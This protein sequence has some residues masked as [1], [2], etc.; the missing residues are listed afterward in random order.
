MG[1][2]FGRRYI[3]KGGAHFS[4]LQASLSMIFSGQSVTHIHTHT[5]TH[6]HT[7]FSPSTSVLKL[8]SHSREKSLLLSSCPSVR[9]SACISRAPT[10]RISWKFGMWKLVWKPVKIVQIWLK[11]GKISGNFR[12]YL[13]RFYGRRWHLIATVVLFSTDMVSGC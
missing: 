9:L 13:N 2:V 4:P 5:H 12:K 11:P 3:K 7:D 6:T 10:R 1:R 8:F